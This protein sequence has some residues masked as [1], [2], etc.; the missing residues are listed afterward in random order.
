[1]TA[2][3]P[4]AAL[5]EELEAK[6]QA[7]ERALQLSRLMVQHAAAAIRATH[8]REPDL[9]R[10]H[11]SA[12]D[13]LAAEIK[14]ALANY[15]DLFAAGYVQD[16]LKEYVESY[17]VAAL[18]EGTALPSPADLG[19]GPAAYLNGLGEAASELRRTILD[20]IR[21]GELASCEPL[22]DRMEEV[23]IGLMAFDYPEALTG[24]LKRTTDMLRGVLER[25]RGDWTV[26]FRQHELEKRL[27]RL[28]EQLPS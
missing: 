18:I 12:A 5:R 26:A 16:A 27:A 7:R 11:R 17:A 25:T 13:A 19:V 23:Y 15:P 3:D 9:A 20:S 14:E 10:Q 22:L 2:H 21:R 8:R 4:L 24:G 1:M 6:H 28:E